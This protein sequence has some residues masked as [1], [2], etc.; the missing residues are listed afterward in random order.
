MRVVVTGMGVVAPNAHGLRAFERALRNGSSGIRFIEEM[1][2]GNFRCQV[3]GI[4]KGIDRLKYEYL[5]EQ[6]LFAMND[7][8]IYGAIAA[9]DCWRDAKLPENKKSP[10]WDTGAIIGT[11]ICGLNTIGKRLV[12]KV[13]AGHVHR[14]GSTLVEQVMTSAPSANIGGILGLGGHVTT[15]SSACTTGTESIASAYFKIRQGQAKRMLA[16]GTEGPSVYLWAGFDAMRV[17]A[18]NFN[19]APEIASRPLSESACGF[20]PASGSGLL[21]LESL[22]SALSRSANIYAEIIGAHVNSGGQREGGTVTFPNANGVIRCIQKSM[23]MA[24]IEAKDI[25]LI[26][27]HLTATKADCYE[28]T[29]WKNALNVEPEKMPFINASKSLFGHAFSA[30]GSIE[31]IATLLQLSNNFVH[32]SINCEDLNPRL[33][34]YQNAIVQQT[35]EERINIAVKASFGFGDVNGCVIFKKYND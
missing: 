8:M 6:Q 32:G 10:D 2:K 30:A 5:S 9:I 21:M 31:C 16:G 17:L 24:K 12:P 3:A 27:G 22:E 35:R 25:N 13:D 1:A 34:A 29:N 33:E 26:N 20:V 18:K 15:N 28:I 23:H 14:L 4:P 19:D 11:G 7:G